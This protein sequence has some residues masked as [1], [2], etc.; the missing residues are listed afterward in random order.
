[1]FRVVNILPLL[2]KNKMQMLVILQNEPTPVKYTIPY[3]VPSYR[4]ALGSPK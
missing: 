2:A 3:I 1:M 4:M